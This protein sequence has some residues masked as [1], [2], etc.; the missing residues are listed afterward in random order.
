MVAGARRSG[1]WD[2]EKAIWK[3]KGRKDQF[4]LGIQKAFMKEV[5]HGKDHPSRHK[6]AQVPEPL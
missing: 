4:Q 1:V 6:K 2:G 3:F 5:A